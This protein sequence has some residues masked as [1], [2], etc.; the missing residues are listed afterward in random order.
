M[1][2][3]TATT[4]DKTVIFAGGS[5][6]VYSYQYL[7]PFGEAMANACYY[8]SRYF[9]GIGEGFKAIFSFDFSN[10]GSVV[11]MGGMLSTESQQIGWART[12]FFYGGYLSLN[13]AIFNLLPFP[14]LDGWQ[15]LVTIV[16]GSV[17]HDVPLNRGRYSDH[18]DER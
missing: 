14:G 11:A 12:F 1:V 18:S 7:A 13:L 10:L 3:A 17:N 2:S 8:Y 9:T 15:L 5:L 6:F 4:V 16:E